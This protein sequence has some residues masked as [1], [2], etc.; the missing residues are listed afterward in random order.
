MSCPDTDS[1]QTSPLRTNGPFSAET[2]GPVCARTAL[3]AGRALLLVLPVVLWSSCLHF[4]PD[5]LCPR[6]SRA[7]SSE[8]VSG[9]SLAPSET[10][11]QVCSQSDSSSSHPCLARV[12]S[13]AW[14][15]LQA[16]AWRKKKQAQD[17]ALA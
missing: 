15:F 6:D 1:A 3:P 11:G 10:W 14:E 4:P 17:E 13:L 8:P 9:Q 16:Q 5:S 2:R 7:A 12:P